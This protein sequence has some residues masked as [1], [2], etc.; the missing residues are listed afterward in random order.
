MGEAV[1]LRF[2]EPTEY[3]RTIPLFCACF[4]T[5]EEFLEEYYGHAKDRSGTVYRNRIAVLEDEADGRIVSMAHIQPMT[6]EYRNRELPVSYLMCIATA[7]DCRHRGYMDRVLGLVTETLAEEGEEW[8]F[9]VPVDRAI[10]RHLGFIH[11]WRFRPE[12]A[13]ILAAD[14]GLEFCS[15]AILPGAANA[16]WQPPERVCLR[17]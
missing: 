15:A 8:C 11:D 2:L 3:E 10:Y 7:E 16:D 1:K 6:A 14:D 17:A 9:L 12:E 4:G 13:E 5:D